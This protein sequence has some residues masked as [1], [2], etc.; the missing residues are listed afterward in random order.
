M[1]PTFPELR[2]DELLYS[3]IARCNALLRLSPVVLHDQFFGE[4]ARGPV[5]IDLPGGLI[6]L[7][8][9]LPRP[10]LLTGEDI[11]IGHTTFPYYAPF[12]TKERRERARELLLH[13]GSRGIHKLLGARCTAVRPSEFLRFC[14]LCA[15]ED[16]GEGGEPAS[17]RRAHQMPGVRICPVHLCPLRVTTASR[18]SGAPDRDRYIPLTPAVRE[19]SRVDTIRAR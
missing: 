14:P 16:V 4:G 2:R 18:R 5:A 10:D 9:R 13:R 15:E 1:L 6:A 7:S 8:Q 11:L 19:A 17:W 12:V 3:G